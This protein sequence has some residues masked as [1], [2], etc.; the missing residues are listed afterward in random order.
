MDTAER[1]PL[2]RARDLLAR[3]MGRSTATRVLLY[4]KF[5]GAVTIG[6]T[7]VAYDPAVAAFTITD[8]D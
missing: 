8:A 7:R 1:Y 5:R 4:A 6:G 2:S 3:Q